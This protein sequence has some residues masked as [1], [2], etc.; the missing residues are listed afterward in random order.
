MKINEG[1][2]AC[3]S[4]EI[5]GGITPVNEHLKE[6]EEEGNKKTEE[7]IQETENPHASK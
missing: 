5:I 3:Q 6:R 1:L 2:W 4:L 7:W